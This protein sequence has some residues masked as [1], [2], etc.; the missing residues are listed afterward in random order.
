MNQPKTGSVDEVAVTNLLLIAET[1]L[2]PNGFRSVRESLD[3]IC[4]YIHDALGCMEVRVRV[5][6]ESRN[7]VLGGRGGQLE[8]RMDEVQPLGNETFSTSVRGQRNPSVEVF[9]NGRPQF[10]QLSDFDPN[11]EAY[12]H[13]SDFGAKATY[14]APVLREGSVVGVLTCY[15]DEARELG[16]DEAVLIG[17]MCRL[18][19]VSLATALIADDSAKLHEGLERVHQ[20]LQVDNATLRDI[21]LAQSRMI[22][23]LADGSTLA[24]EQTVR[25][26]SS[27]L[28]RS[29]LACGGDGTTYAIEATPEHLETLESAAR[30]HCCE[31]K[32]K[33]ARDDAQFTVIPI[34]RPGSSGQLGAL[35]VTPAIDD[36][37]EFNV[38]IARQAALVIGSHIQ[39]HAADTTL[40]NHALPTALLAIAHGLYSEPQL[41]EV[42]ALLLSVTADTEL[43]VAVIPTATPEAA[44]RLSRKRSVLT[45][46][47]WPVLTAVADGRSVLV[48]LR[49]G[50]VEARCAKVMLSLSH[51][52]ECVG[53]SSTVSGLGEL[54]RGRKQ[55]LTACAVASS[56]HSAAYFDDLGLFVD[57]TGGMPVEQMRAFSDKVLSPIREYDERRGTDL[58]QTL[59]VYVEKNGQIPEAANTLSVHVNTMHQ[60]VGRI[61][62][63]AGM[64]LRSYRDIARLSLAIDMLP[65]VTQV[66]DTDDTH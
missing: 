6:D 1:A 10:L 16:D 21:H 64:N 3:H 25:I 62:E 23:L 52:A 58:L 27:A 65:T 56:A 51:E 12:G 44:F 17:L 40:S 5:L 50:P 31:S 7:L 34:E 66:L 4:Q 41:K 38:V 54:E 61:E 15:W 32:R 37:E 57:V 26:V 18:A 29:V 59:K 53:F 19:S 43:S 14:F 22:Q 42:G 9:T 2:G 49:G 45:G 55:A 47:G 24:V 11:S 35:I 60:R 20:Q 8:G 13:L 46:A 28:R 48:L 33:Q 36:K 39:E 30:T 63:I